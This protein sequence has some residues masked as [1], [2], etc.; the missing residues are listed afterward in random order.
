MIK[1]LTS[2]MSVDEI[3]RGKNMEQLLQYVFNILKKT[4]TKKLFKYRE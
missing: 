2:I 1:E 4:E 3:H